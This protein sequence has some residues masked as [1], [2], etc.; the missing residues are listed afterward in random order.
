M[1]ILLYDDY[2]ANVYLTKVW[3]EISLKFTKRKKVEWVV[4]SNIII[5]ISYLI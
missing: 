3:G 4:T 1:N 2:L 5:I